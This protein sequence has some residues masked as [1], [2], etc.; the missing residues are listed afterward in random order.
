MMVKTKVMTLEK[1]SRGRQAEESTVCNG[2]L[3]VKSLSLGKIIQSAKPTVVREQKQHWQNLVKEGWR[4]RPKGFIWCRVY[5]FRKT[6]SSIFRESA[7]LTIIISTEADVL[8]RA[9]FVACTSSLSYAVNGSSFA[10]EW[11]E[12][13]WIDHPAFIFHYQ[14]FFVDSF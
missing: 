11:E 9:L 8:C 5:I 1:V 12:R 2:Y 7:L 3:Y 4:G 14:P 13:S 10:P 6:F